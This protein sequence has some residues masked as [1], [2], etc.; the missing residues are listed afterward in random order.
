MASRWLSNPSDRPASRSKIR[1]SSNQLRDVVVVRF[2]R[3]AKV[4]AFRAGR[5]NNASSSRCIF[6]WE[7]FMQSCPQSSGQLIA[8]GVPG[9]YTAAVPVVVASRCPSA[10]RVV[11][12]PDMGMLMQ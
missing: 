8:A 9:V 5:F 12:A 7:T 4:T 11:T 6:C 3:R 1:T 10:H 2:M